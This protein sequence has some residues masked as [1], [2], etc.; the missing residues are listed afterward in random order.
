[1]VT[2]TTKGC[3]SEKETGDSLFCQTCREEWI[4][5]CKETEIHELDAPEEIVSNLLLVF[6]KRMAVDEQP[7]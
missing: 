2:C 3:F 5:W 7:K 6:Q 4:G 1:M